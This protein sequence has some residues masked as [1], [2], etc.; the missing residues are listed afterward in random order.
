MAAL[1][2]TVAISHAHF[3]GTCHVATETEELNF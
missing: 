2:N 3:L 1:S